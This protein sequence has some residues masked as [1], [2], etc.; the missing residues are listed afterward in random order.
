[1]QRTVR[2]DPFVQEL[3]ERNA[4]TKKPWVQPGLSGHIWQARLP[5]GL[6]AGTHRLVVQ[7]TDAHG[8]RLIGSMILEVA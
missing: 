6:P 2:L 3:Y 8:A 5:A 4:A 1:M 7:A